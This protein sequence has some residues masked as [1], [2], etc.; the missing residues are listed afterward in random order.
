MCWGGLLSC[1]NRASYTVS[2][3]PIFSTHSAACLPIEYPVSASHLSRM[4]ETIRHLLPSVPGLLY[5]GL[6]TDRIIKLLALRKSALLCWERNTQDNDKSLCFERIFQDVLTQFEGDAEEFLF[7]RFQ[8]ELI[9]QLK[10]PLDLGYE[11]ILF[12]ITQIRVLAISACSFHK[13]F[14]RI[15]SKQF[16]A[17]TPLGEDLDSQSSDNC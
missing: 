3:W 16:E 7:P 2:A 10:T 4:Q 15:L 9:H 5:S 6:G 13:G 14:H 17:L 12:D 1:C 8:D 11:K